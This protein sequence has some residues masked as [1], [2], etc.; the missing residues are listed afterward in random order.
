MAYG[1]HETKLKIPKATEKINS[2]FPS[3]NITTQ[4]RAVF[5]MSIRQYWHPCKG[6][7]AIVL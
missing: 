4:L 1:S 7:H 6:K 5:V 2:P 3:E